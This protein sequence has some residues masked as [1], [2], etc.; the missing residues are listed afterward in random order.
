MAYG[1][2][3]SNGGSGAYVRIK[4]KRPARFGVTAAWTRTERTGGG[5]GT[6]PDDYKGIPVSRGIR[7]EGMREGEHPPA[8]AV[9]LILAAFQKI[10]Y[11]S[12]S[13][14]PIPFAGAWRSFVGGGRGGK[15][16]PEKTFSPLHA[17]FSRVAR[18]H[19]TPTLHPLHEIPLLADQIPVSFSRHKSTDENASCC[20]DRFQ[21]ETT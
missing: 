11:P 2:S 17:V 5:E 4:E 8:A 7:S 18:F 3:V 20:P 19:P 15:K 12:E 1:G 6:N 14:S 10:G 9:Q 16:A 21:N 13:S